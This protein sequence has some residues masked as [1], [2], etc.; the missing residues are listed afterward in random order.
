[1]QALAAFMEAIEQ[2]QALDRHSVRDQAAREFDTDQIVDSIIAAVN[3][4]GLAG[5][6][7]TAASV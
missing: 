2:A 7:Q 5:G 6:I 3:K 1:M 4:A